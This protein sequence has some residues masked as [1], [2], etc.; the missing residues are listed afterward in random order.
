M[1]YFK[2]NDLL[3]RWQLKSETYYGEFPNHHLQ[4]HSEDQRSS[5]GVVFLTLCEKP[6]Q[7]IRRSRG[8]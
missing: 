4:V 5:A 1:T 2:S 8:I 6:R 7:P 3:Q